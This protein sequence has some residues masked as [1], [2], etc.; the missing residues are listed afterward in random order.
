VCFEYKE[1]NLERV[2]RTERQR[3]SE[4]DVEGERAKVRNTQ[5]H[6]IVL[7][8]RLKDLFKTS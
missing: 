6:K 5:L 3:L 7:L 8:K 4:K 1:R 2:Q